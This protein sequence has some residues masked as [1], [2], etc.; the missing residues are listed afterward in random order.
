M[1]F[2]RPS[3]MAA[4]LLVGLAAVGATWGAGMPPSSPVSCACLR[5]NSA[6]DIAGLTR[7]VRPLSELLSGLVRSP[8]A[9]LPR[10]AA[11][12]ARPFVPPVESVARVQPRRWRS[13]E[14][15][16]R[17]VA[18]R[19]GREVLG[20]AS[21]HGEDIRRPLGLKHSYPTESA[22][23]VADFYKGS[24]LVIGAKKR[25]SGFTLRATDADVSVGSGPVVEGPVVSLLLATTGRRAAL[26]DLD[27]PGL[28]LLRS[29]S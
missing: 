21:P 15:G 7:P 8:A 25:I 9:D 2:V 4:G 1:G 18:A 6:S 14:V 17:P 3:A 10:L 13:V 24:N 20:W 16:F 28:E 23:R 12:R 22:V 11:P 29:R 5:S 19:P 26:D 27:G